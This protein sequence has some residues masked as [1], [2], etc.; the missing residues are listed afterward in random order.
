[1]KMQLKH[2][3]DIITLDENEQSE[4]YEFYRFH[5]TRERVIE[6][7]E[8]NTSRVFKSEDDLKIVTNRVLSLMDDN[9]VS[10]DEAI[11][12]VIADANYINKYTENL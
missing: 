7:L 5:C 3:N 6:V 12:A 4:V 8:N 2:N 9:H 10:E 11:D 1:M